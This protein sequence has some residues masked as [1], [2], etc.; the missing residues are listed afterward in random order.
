MEVVFFRRKRFKLNLPNRTNI[1]TWGAGKK[2]LWTLSFPLL[3]PYALVMYVLDHWEIHPNWPTR[4]G[5]LT[6]RGMMPYGQSVEFVDLIKKCPKSSWVAFSKSHI[7]FFQTGFGQQNPA[8][9]WHSG[10][11]VTLELVLGGEEGVVRFYWPENGMAVLKLSEEEDLVV[12]NYAQL[13][14]AGWSR[15]M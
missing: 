12:K 11:E 13:H 8:P 15:F 5:T 9:F 3:I 1:G 6:V 2:L 4:V 10:P 7:A 14:G